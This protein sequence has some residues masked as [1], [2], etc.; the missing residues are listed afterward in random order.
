MSDTK[1]GHVS[2]DIALLWFNFIF[3]K[4]GDT[5]KDDK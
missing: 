1:L 4:C 5:E 3:T 2:S